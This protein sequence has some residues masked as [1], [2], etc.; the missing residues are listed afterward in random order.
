[1]RRIQS[2]LLQLCL[3]LVLACAALPAC[4]QERS[5]LQPLPAVPPPPP[6]MA[7][8]DENL[9]PEVTI[10]KREGDTIEEHRIN[11]KLFKIKVTP[12]HGVP[13]TLI[14]RNGDGNFTQTTMGSADVSVPQWVIGTF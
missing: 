10:K 14:D 13:Y 9:E 7:A 5:D 4:A 2:A 3:P 12:A 6:E 1:M 8:F 11:G